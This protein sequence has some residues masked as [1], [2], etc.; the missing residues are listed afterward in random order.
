MIVMPIYP[1]L[2]HFKAIRPHQSPNK[3]SLEETKQSQPQPGELEDSEDKET[4]QESS[5][6][7]VS[8]LDESMSAARKYYKDDSVLLN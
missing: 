2:N 3:E 6:D 5:S 1:K 7:W 4:R 8:I